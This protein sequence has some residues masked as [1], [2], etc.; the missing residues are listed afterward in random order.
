E[1]KSQSSFL[2]MWLSNLRKQGHVI[3]WKEDDSTGNPPKGAS[4][5]Q[6]QR[7]SKVIDEYAPEKAENSE[8]ETIVGH[9]KR[10]SKFIREYEG[11]D[12]EEA[13]KKALDLNKNGKAWDYVE[14]ALSKKDQKTR[15]AIFHA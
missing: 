6:T 14:N 9:W 11:V 7:A 13:D 12:M 2:G 4:K 5:P 1:L 3:E 15:D 8:V 10:L